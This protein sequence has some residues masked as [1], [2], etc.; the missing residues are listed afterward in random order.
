LYLQQLQVLCVYV[1]VMQR[2]SFIAQIKFSELHS[3]S[4]VAKPDCV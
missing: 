3:V 4:K 1:E 2:V